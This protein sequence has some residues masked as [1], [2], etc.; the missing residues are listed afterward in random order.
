MIPSGACTL[1][2]LGYELAFYAQDGI[3][4]DAPDWATVSVEHAAQGEGDDLIPAYTETF[5]GANTLL[6]F[7]GD[8]GNQWTD[9]F[10]R[11]GTDDE[12]TAA[13][14]TIWACERPPQ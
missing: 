4:R 8:D 13:N 2:T 11:V 7:Y 1:P 12:R 3:H 10:G 5:V 14:K 6:N 9:A